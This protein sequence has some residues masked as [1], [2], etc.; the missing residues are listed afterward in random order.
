MKTLS[1][2]LVAF[3]FSMGHSYGEDSKV[4]SGT[5]APNERAPHERA[6]HEATVFT[7]YELLMNG[8]NPI[9][10]TNPTDE[11]GVATNDARILDLERTYGK[12]V[13]RSPAVVGEAILNEQLERFQADKK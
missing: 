9:D 5:G 2:I 7:E 10:I 1:L 4:L 6:P 8:V 3:I 13:G 11:Y 12:V